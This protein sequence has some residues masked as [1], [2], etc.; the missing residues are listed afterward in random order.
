MYWVIG[1]AQTDEPWLLNLDATYKTEARAQSAINWQRIGQGQFDPP[2][3]WKIITTDE[4][5]ELLPSMTRS[6]YTQEAWER[7]CNGI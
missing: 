1:A 4:L 6:P 5:R 7:F 2:G 3:Y